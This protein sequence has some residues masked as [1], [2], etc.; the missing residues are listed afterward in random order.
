[1]AV[2]VGSI[3]IGP[4]KNYVQAPGLR[5][6][7]ATP[8]ALSVAI[9]GTA[10]ATNPNEMRNSF[11]KAAAEVAERAN[12]EDDNENKSKRDGFAS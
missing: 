3:G 7:S 2:L 11:G 1:M 12:D 9:D 5:A 10:I 6:I 4:R 8:V